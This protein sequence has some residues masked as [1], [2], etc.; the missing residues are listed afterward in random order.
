MYFQVECHPYLNQAK[1][2]AFCLERG[3]VLT[4]YCPLGSPERPWQKPGDLYI[5]N[6]PKIKEIANKYGKSSAQIMIKYNLQLGNIVIPKSSNKTRITENINIFDF[7]LSADD[8]KYID[9]FDC[10]G[11][12]CP[13]AEYDQCFGLTHLKFLLI[14]DAWSTLII[15]SNQMWSFSMKFL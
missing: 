12:I 1:L 11:R 13:Y 2:R 3:I 10:N 7:Q 4:S 8:M 9:T 5:L 6:D 15:L 14:T